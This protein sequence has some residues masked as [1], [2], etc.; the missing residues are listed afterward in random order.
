[1]NRIYS[2]RYSVVARGFIAVS[3]FA[4]KCKLK[5]ARRLSFPFLLFIPLLFTPLL[6]SAGCFA[7]TVNNELG[8][9]LFR[10]FAENK[11]MFHPGVTDIAI[12]N[13]QGELVGMLNKAVMPDFSSV[14]SGIGVATLVDPQY[15]VSVKH[16]G[17][18][19]NV[20]FGD[21]GNLYNIVDR[22][23]SSSLDFHAPR[24]DK[25]VT[26]VAPAA[27]TVQGA[28]SGAYLDKDRYPVFFRLGSGTQYIKDSNG[29]LTQIGGA[30]S[31][32]MGGTV[33]SL[34]SYQNGEMISTSSGLVFDY[35]LNGAMPIYGEAGDS[36]SPLFAFDTVQNKW[37]LVGVLTGGNG[38]GGR[39]NNWA[40]IPL[41]FLGQK[42]NEDNDATVTFSASGN[43]ALTWTFDSSTG[44]GNL[45]QGSTEY[46]MHGQQ[47][48][49]LNAGKNLIFQ[50]KN[51]QI[52]LKNSV[53]QGAGSLTF[54]DNYTVTTTNGSTW[55][56]AGIIVD[57]KASVNWQVN[58]VKG[59]NLHKI[60]EGTLV[61][62][63]TGINE[64]GL[65]VGDGKVVLNQQ[66]DNKGQVQ[67]FS[68]VNI[69][70]GRPTVVLT[71]GRQVNPDT[72]SWG[73]RGGTLDINGNNL[74]FRRLNAAD[75]G[76]VLANNAE[77]HSTVTLNYTMKASDVVLNNWSDSQT[78][79]A[80]DL[81][82]CN[83]P[84]TGK[85]D[86]YILKKNNYGY[87]PLDQTSN[88]DWEF[89]G[90]SLSDAQQVVADRFNASGYLFHGQLKGNLNV[91]NS[92]PVGAPGALVLDG[93]AEISGTFSQENGRLTLQGHPVIHAYNTQSV[94]DKL[95][96]TGDNSVLTQPTS[97]S[98][99]DWENRSFT[100]DRLSLRNTDFGL[101]R[102]A[103]LNTS[104]DATDSTVTLGDSR[105]FI[106]KK[107]GDGTAFV[108]EEGTSEAVKE[109]DRSVFNGSAVLNGKTTL[110]I[111]NATFSGDITGHTGSHVELSRRSLWN[112]T[113]SST[114]DSFRS[115]GGTLSLVTENWSPKTLTVNTMHASSMQI[116]MG[117]STA[118]STS[119]RIDILN[120]ATGGHNTL[121]LS[122]LFDQTV[123]L[124]ND[125]TLA[126]APGGTSHGYFSF[127]S[128]NR[129]F[130]VYTPDTQVQEKDG[131]VIWQLKN[132]AGIVDTQVSDGASDIVSG[133][134]QPET[135]HTGT[136]GGGMAAEDNSHGGAGL[137]SVL[138][139]ENTDIAVNGSSLFNGAD[140]VSLL[141][142][143]RD[144]FAAREFILSDSA[145]R[146]QQVVD[147]SD[148][149]G[150][151]WAMTGYSN[152]GY[153]D[154]TLNQ[155][156][157]NVGYR[158]SGVGDAWWG[159][160]AEL[161]RGHS[162]TDDYR[163]DFSLW[164][165]HVLAGKSFFSGLFVDGMAG[166][167]ELSED[168]TIG[169]EL[170]DLSGKVKSHILTAGVRSGWNIY[171]ESLDMTIT[172]TVSLNGART[173]EHRLQGRERSVV[174]HG[175]EAFWLKVGIGAEKMAGGVTLKAGIWRTVTLN[176]MPGMTLRDDWKARHYDAEK[177][178]RYTVSFGV[179]GKLTEKLSVQAKVNSSFDG[180][181]KTDAE[182][183]VGVRYDF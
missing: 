9:Q 41:D 162:S 25:L 163:D 11:G 112:M 128:L 83:N 120:K 94:A 179:N 7:G 55:T 26:E 36:G 145:D 108:L 109:A 40:V 159:M 95:A 46:A 22:N 58:G 144:M 84:Y 87:Y 82:I 137:P 139:E 115:R 113:K 181:F 135:N 119:D 37:V 166:Y 125:L 43:D 4:R 102:N 80:G 16:N 10:D 172:P 100:F 180:Y 117:V 156:G 111:M 183:V 147:N 150:G 52:D 38:A 6:F 176:D 118:D 48:N 61:V 123:T 173:D 160:G 106:D 148:A 45:T 161:Y 157:L 99:E 27:V 64:G 59:D 5:T 24:L 1:M 63:G 90:T 158:P 20:R 68:S 154:F 77:N 136:G 132:N 182:G 31:W 107:D 122:S 171:T 103:T 130:T 141:K 138:P 2:L 93:S 62:Q 35:N 92:L 177:A 164:G 178:D 149:T 96:S 97:F 86:Y 60:G 3:E 39:G 175:G 42:F 15:I 101:G 114:L 65:K 124:K 29:Q 53:S 34:S 174:L 131:K 19:Q 23:E 142:K 14:D 51:G 33:G 74:T 70:S 13:K 32:L 30:Y 151:L 170:S 28:V 105:V 44:T 66:A 17:G 167:R 165:V 152:G 89:V 50:G 121:D 169:G 75:Y 129:G 79:T 67:A 76:A 127:A 126:S 72:V 133:P 69:A 73:Y 18:Y 140:N 143:A 110:D 91:E 88:E 8:Y 56:G 47:G 168:Y 153:G 12:Y 54:R 57:S 85:P 49:D 98:Q 155:H 81:Y 146:W 78:G 104:I 116:A 134:A 21:G 71:D